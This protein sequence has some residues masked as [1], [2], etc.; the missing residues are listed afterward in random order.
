MDKEFGLKDQLLDYYAKTSAASEIYSSKAD[1]VYNWGL[2][3]IGLLSV[4]GVG[5]TIM[6]GGLLTK[7]AYCGAKLVESTGDFSNFTNAFALPLNA[8]AGMAIISGAVIAAGQSVKDSFASRIEDKSSFL[9]EQSNY[10]SAAYFALK[11]G[12]LELPE[13][14]NIED[15]LVAIRDQQVA[16]HLAQGGE[17]EDINSFYPE[18]NMERASELVGKLENNNAR[19]LE[20]RT[21]A[22]LEQFRRCENN[23]AEIVASLEAIVQ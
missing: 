1:K 5:G 20:Y 12:E 13:G 15:A 10:A 17:E 2:Q 18:I 23:N 8:V 21:S 6:L 4:E 16:D 22:N 9:V 19:E 14:A 11:K 3:E 7:L